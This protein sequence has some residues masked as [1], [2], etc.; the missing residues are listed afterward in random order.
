[1]SAKVSAARWAY[2]WY[3]F[4]LV[5]TIILSA[6]LG[7]LVAALSQPLFGAVVFVVASALFVWK[8][9]GRKIRYYGASIRRRKR[10]LAARAF[11]DSKVE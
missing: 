11:A 10:R 8:W 7:I 6:L 5:C 4:L 2:W 9:P 1:M 3:W